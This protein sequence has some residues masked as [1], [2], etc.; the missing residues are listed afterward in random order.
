MSDSLA[1]APLLI[2]T[3]DLGVAER[4]REV[5]VSL[6][7][8]QAGSVRIPPDICA[9][10]D[11]AL[12]EGNVYRLIFIDTL[13]SSYPA[14]EIYKRVSTNLQGPTIIL[15]EGENEIAERCRAL[16]APYFLQKALIG[17][18]AL[19]D[20]LR[21][22]TQHFGLQSRLKRSEYRFRSM[23]NSMSDALF[24]LEADPTSDSPEDSRVTF[25]NPAAAKMFFG[26]KAVEDLASH[27][28]GDHIRLTCWKTV[29]DMIRTVRVVNQSTEG[30]LEHQPIPGGE[31]LWFRVQVVPS[32]PDIALIFRDI[33][34]RRR[35]EAQIHY[36]EQRFRD[37]ADS[38]SDWLWEIDT[39]G[40]VTFVSRGRNNAG[41]LIRRGVPFSNAFLPEDRERVAADFATLFTDPKPFHDH[42]YWGVDGNG[43]R[44]CWSVS[45]TPVRDES[46][47][48]LG[49]RGVS[50]DISVEKASQDQLY[51]MANNDT[52]TGLYNRGRFYDELNRSIRQMKRYGRQGA[53]LLMDL[54]RFKYVN[55]TFGHEAGDSMLVHIAEILRQNIRAADIIARLGGDEFALIMPEVEP[56]DALARASQILDL[57]KG[58]QFTY[59]GHEISMSSS[60]GIVMF[61]SQG[62]ATGELLS[63]ADIAMY[64]A[65][66]QGRNRLHMFDESAVRDHAMAKRIEVVDFIIRCLDNERIELHFQPIVPI[67]DTTN[68]KHYEVLCR[69]LDDNGKIVPPVH[70]IETAED[71]GLISRIDE[72]VCRKSLEA[73]RKLHNQGRP[74]N[75]AINLS[76]LTFDDEDTLKKI[77][78]ML[79]EAA[80]PRGAVIFEITE[81]A[82][83]KDIG[84]AQRAIRELK[85]YG[86]E[87]ALDDFGVGYSSFN[88][89]KHLDIDFVKIDGSFI[90][91]LNNSQDDRLFVKALTDMARAMQIQTVAEMVED[92]SIVEHL[93]GIGIDFGQGY[94]FGKPKPELLDGKI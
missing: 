85:K 26:D 39:R 74:I 79:A 1:K 3:P 83:L 81:T 20:G 23:A 89:I 45:G 33:T 84:R 42:E 53:V 41:L 24:F 7:L 70:F 71:F 10:I 36:S 11:A 4:I 43:Q 73:L 67:H 56:S 75:L 2:L 5:Y 16:E 17:K 91:N 15:L 78:E 86:C 35:A 76:G 57:L 37:I 30:E 51:Y 27:R 19:A 61:P 63:K 59:G 62:N 88:Y 50:R 87:F 94:H 48:L 90:K 46:G 54:D 65:K 21:G 92:Q 14:D 52:L 58:A 64:R 80:M 18:A 31:S 8:F 66:Q 22:A 38:F 13:L 44:V 69:M 29:A 72:Y 55:D 34:Y 25:Y 68:P 40:H 47:D 77:G 32:I 49:Y 6:G 9:D 12:A 82:A 60:I 28:I 93:R